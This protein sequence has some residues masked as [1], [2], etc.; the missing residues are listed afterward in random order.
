MIDYVTFV[1]KDSSEQKFWDLTGN[2]SGSIMD[3]PGGPLGVAMGL[4]YRDL[5][6]QFDPDPVVSAGLQL[7]HS[8]ASDKGRL[9][10]QGS[11]SGAE[12]AAAGEPAIRR[13]AG[14]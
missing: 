5:K 3:L 9:R 2:L 6:G 13:L 4:E 10:R 11:L 8:R 12:C 14:T 7:R 1:Q